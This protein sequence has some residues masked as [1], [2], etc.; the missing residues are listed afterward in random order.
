MNEIFKKLTEEIKLQLN[1]NLQTKEA[2]E[3]ITE[4]KAKSD[5]G[6]F[7]FIAS[8]PAVD[9]QGESIDQT[10]W[11]L[12][13]YLKNS[14]LLWAHDYSQPPIGVVDK[15]G[16]EN[17]NLVIEGRFA[18]TEFAQQIRKL[19]D[20]QMVNTVSVGFIPKEMNG[21]VITK[22]ELLEVSVVPV[23]A[24]PQA[25]SLRQI[26]EAGVELE[27]LKTKGFEIEFKDTEQKGAV[28]DRLDAMENQTF[29]SVQEKWDNVDD[30][31]EIVQAFCGVYLQPETKPEQFK[32]L[33][34]EAAAMLTALAE[35]PEGEDMA[36]KSI[37]AAAVKAE[38]FK[39]IEFQKVKAGRVL[40][41]KNRTLIKS[42]IDGLT[43]TKDALQELYDATEQGDKKV[44][45]PSQKE[46]ETKTNNQ[47]SEADI[48]AMDQW[49]LVKKLTGAAAT[50]L[51][52]AGAIVN[53]TLD[54]QKIIN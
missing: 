27:M 43:A 29:D 4:T 46:G 18:P 47:F 12:E 35:N 36:E 37:V 20:L 42:T 28:Q 11:E 5:S 32:E 15:I 9:R 26:K 25:L 44:D 41:E 49:L 16:L 19:Y 50:A 3:V 48:K 31:Y 13:N 51:S 7:K 23:P 33:L 10:G 40:S 17:G 22:S 24:N 45:P 39:L 52:E 14:V 54:A 6:N 1:T 8:T 53:K 30:V 2:Q 38:K 34:L 21:N